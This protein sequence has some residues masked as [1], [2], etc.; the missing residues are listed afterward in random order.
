MTKRSIAHHA[1]FARDVAAVFIMALLLWAT[2]VALVVKAVG[3]E[4]FGNPE[5]PEEPYSAVITIQPKPE[6][7]AELGPSVSELM[8]ELCPP[9]TIK[10]GKCEIIPWGAFEAMEGEPEEVPQ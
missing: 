3:A 5:K 10:A 1:H 6:P 9:D 8:I 7:P 2:V 4:E